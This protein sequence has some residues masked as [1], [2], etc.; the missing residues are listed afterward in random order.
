[1]TP[2]IAAVLA[3]IMLAVM[4]FVTERLG[5]DLVSLLVLVS[6]AL[7]GLVTPAQ[8]LSGFS[9]PAVVTVWA[10]FIL[11]GGL[12][13]TGVANVV[14]RQVLRLA[15]DGEL[16]LV[17]VIMLTAGVMSAFMNN[18]GV[19][20]L[21][22][23]VVMD[24][25]RRT[26]R[27]PSRLLMPLAFGS[28]L[29]GLTTLIGTPPNI[30]I[31][32]AMRE[33]GLRAFQLF[34]YTPVGLAVMLAGVAFMAL[35]GRYLLPIRDL[36]KESTAPGAADLED[37]Y[38]LRER[39]CLLRLPERSTLAGKTLAES[40]LGSSLGLNVIAILRNEHTQ[41]A[42]G[43]GAILQAGDRLLVEGR[44][45]RLANLRGRRHLVVEH[46]SLDVERLISQE[47]HLAR[48]ELS[49]RS[50]LVGQTL[51]EIDFRRRFGV[52][53]LAIWRDEVPMWKDLDN[54]PLR[55][56][57]VL[58]VQGATHAQIEALRD[59]SEFSVSSADQAEVVSLHE[60]LMVVCVPDEST[61]A[62]KTLSESRL[63]DLFGMT[64]LGLVR[65]DPRQLVSAEED[66]LQAGDIL[67]VKGEPDDLLRLRALQ[68]LE[69]DREPI[70]DLHDLESDQVGM[71]EAVLS[72]HTTL[73]GRTVRQIHFREKYGLNVLAIWRAGR[74]YRSNLRD[75][76]LRFGDALLLH[77]RRDRLRLLGSEPDFLV[78]TEE[79]QEM[80]L[81]SKA[82]LAAIVMGAVLLPVILGWLPISIAAVVGATLMVLTGCLTME[83]AYRF[84]EWRAV[85][86]IAGM[87]PLGIAMEQTGAA[88]LLAE[89]MVAAVGGLGPRAV[90][91][92]LYIL[93]TLATQV[94]PNPAVAVLLAPIALDTAGNLG[95]SPYS[96]MMVVALAAS[97]SFLSPVAH[98]ANVLI[99][100]PG[101]YRFSDYIKV[102]APLT[103][104]ALAVTLLAVPL[105]WPL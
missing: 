9:N 8:A 5:M 39:L 93:A 64:V 72:P 10:V 92:G 50:S 22:L 96:L 7:T 63:G 44:L 2:Q 25:A 54:T 88:R 40:R 69:V 87:L 84:I 43:P 65:Q 15:G 81:L 78:L 3:I 36:A 21:L 14:G 79:A 38:D 100:G 58:L 47:I 56:G 35:V 52:I 13:R 94:M 90:M 97:A 76:D 101:G 98:P 91:A 6:L 16:R 24:I 67:L 105:I 53:V 95:V 45:D 75:M 27:P 102:G 28:L 46:G 30:L 86:L 77:G 99:M 74:A 26:G 62:G 57:D 68:D 23:P 41:L 19:A 12:A 61:L 48:V 59:A 17:T 60:R 51:L 70:P 85:F 82:P 29:G 49:T 66:T 32:N 103:L 80:P 11:S 73:A 89:G 4:L 1:M 37:L 55:V 31:S 20:A 33:S 42:P 83:E 104:V 71:V 34:D 18:V